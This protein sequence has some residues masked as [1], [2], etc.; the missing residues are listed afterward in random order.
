[1]LD[2]ENSAIEVDANAVGEIGT[3]DGAPVQIAQATS[4]LPE[5]PDAAKGAR[6]GVEGGEENA[7]DAP[8]TRFVADA[9]NTV[10]LPD[11]LELDNVLAEGRDLILVQAD[12]TRIVIEGGALNVPT[13]VIGEVTIPQQVLIAALQENGLNIAAGPDG[14]V[15]VV[16]TSSSGG[17]LSDGQGSIGDAGEVIDL[18]G[19][20]TFGFDAPTFDAL[21]AAAVDV[22]D[23]PV[24]LDEAGA[25]SIEELE[26]GAEGEAKVD[27]VATGNMTF[28]DPDVADTH[29][30]SYVL[31]SINGAD[32]ELGQFET[33]LVPSASGGG[34]INWKF[35]VNDGAIDYLA[36]GETITQVYAVTVTDA[37]GAFS[38]RNVTV[39]ITGT[40]DAPTISAADATG[41]VTEDASTP[42]LT[43]TGTITFD[44]VDLIDGHSVS[45]VT[46]GGGNTLG[47]TLTAVV[48]DAATG[49]GN[50]TVTWTYT[51]ANAATQYLAVGQTVEETFTVT[52]SDG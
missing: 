19:D 38:T 18:L 16:T 39:T 9:S 25:G 12:G 42:T 40:N 27:L 21:D 37:S 13:F 29:T 8:R 34:T 10:Q 4:E 26:D 20:T 2:R 22:N 31:A 43:D 48:S 45:A 33:S 32:A 7:A 1:M 17:N 30:V 23:P 47:G 51:V 50:G 44:D 28:V 3:H 11:G 41:A 15:S 5:L 52:I 46:P 36:V 35:T 14:T 49:A 24:I 6:V